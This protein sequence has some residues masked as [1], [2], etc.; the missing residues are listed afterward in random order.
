MAKKKALS[1]RAMKKAKGGLNFT[2]GAAAPPEAI[3]IGMLLPAVQK[4]R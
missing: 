3:L 1:R 4:V 2:M